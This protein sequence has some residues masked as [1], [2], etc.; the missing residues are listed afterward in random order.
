MDMDTGPAASVPG[1]D[2]LVRN[3]RVFDG[4]D[5]PDVRGDVGVRHGR[6]VAVEGD[7]DLARLDQGF[8]RVFTAACRP[9]DLYY[10]A[11][12]L[13]YHANLLFLCVKNSRVAA[14]LFLLC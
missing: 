11:N 7:D 5:V 3:V 13:H 6:V 10:R 2:L 8:P 9:S 1:F 4:G 12:L 14:L